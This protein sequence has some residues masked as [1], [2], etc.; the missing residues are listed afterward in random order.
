MD[1]KKRKDNNKNDRKSRYFESWKKEK[2]KSQVLEQNVL[3]EESLDESEVSS[4]DLSYEEQKRDIPPKI[5]KKI[6]RRPTQPAQSPALG[7]HD[8]ADQVNMQNPFIDQRF[9]K[10]KKQAYFREI[11]GQDYSVKSLSYVQN[12]DNYAQNCLELDSVQIQGLNYLELKD[13]KAKMVHAGY[14]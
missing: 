1:L 7:F 14:T 9:L 13:K 3:K 2:S 5:R 12:P 10:E 4:H 8:V 6:D 11:I